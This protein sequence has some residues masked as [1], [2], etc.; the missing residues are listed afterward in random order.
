[1][2]TLDINSK[3]GIIAIG[4]FSIVASLF[5]QI[6]CNLINFI[7]MNEKA[8][9]LLIL[10]GAITIGAGL[11]KKTLPVLLCAIAYIV[12]SIFQLVQFTYPPKSRFFGGGGSLFSLLLG[13]S[14]GL[15]AI[16]LTSYLIKTSKLDDV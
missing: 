13:L 14:V 3:K 8:A 10:L 6:E 16:T 11:S 12:A 15:F 2:K 7:R 4:I 9:V 5:S 1:M